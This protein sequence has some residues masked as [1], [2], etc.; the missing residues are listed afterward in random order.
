M[1]KLD[2]NDVVSLMV[3]NTTNTDNIVVSDIN[4]FLMALPNNV[5]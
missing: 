1:L 2:T 4:V 3:K 5:A